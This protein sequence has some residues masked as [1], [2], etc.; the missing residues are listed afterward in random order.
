MSE[1]VRGNQR[2]LEPAN[3]TVFTEIPSYIPENGSLISNFLH[4]SLTLS[5]SLA[6][7]LLVL[8]DFSQ[9]LCINSVREEVYREREPRP[10]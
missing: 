3:P 8:E 9:R 10:K 5:L 1:D 2:F 6:L 4:L 7:C